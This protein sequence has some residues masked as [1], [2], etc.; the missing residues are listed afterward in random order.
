MDVVK[1]NIEALRGRIEIRSKAGQ[2]TTFTVT[3]PAA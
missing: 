3:F 1:K 2:G